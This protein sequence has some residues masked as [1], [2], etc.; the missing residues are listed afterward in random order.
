VATAARR[1]RSLS[2]GVALSPAPAFAGSGCETKS[3]FVAVKVPLR[4]PRER[5][6]GD[7]PDDS[8]SESARCDTLRIDQGQ[9]TEARLRRG[10]ITGSWCA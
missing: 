5:P 10:S 9:A 2:G 6:Q 1:S 3:A 7:P 8:L 4:T